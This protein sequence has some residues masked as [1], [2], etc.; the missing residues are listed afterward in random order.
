MSTE[1]PAEISAKDIGPDGDN[2]GQLNGQDSNFSLDSCKHQ[3]AVGVLASS[4]L[5]KPY[6]ADVNNIDEAPLLP[7]MTHEQ[8]NLEGLERIRTLRVDIAAKDL[9]V[10][11]MES[12]RRER[13]TRPEA[14]CNIADALLQRLDFKPLQALQN[15]GAYVQPYAAML[16][17][18][19]KNSYAD[20]SYG[21]FVMENLQH[22][23]KPVSSSKSSWMPNI[24]QIQFWEAVEEIAM[25]DE[26]A[27]KLWDTSTSPK[28]S[29]L[30]SHMLLGQFP[31]L[32][33]SLRHGE[34]KG[35]M[36]ERRTQEQ[37]LDKAVLD[38]K[39]DKEESLRKKLGNIK[40]N[41]NLKFA[42]SVIFSLISEASAEAVAEYP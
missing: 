30:K 38:G 39:E 29:M 9:I 11:K 34:T 32:L 31:I 4:V 36:A 20:L 25:Q 21:N 14:L 8:M 42:A 15:I 19:R 16:V 10:S 17:K 24:R 3:R 40:D 35:I 37:H 28:P 18:T 41:V 27:A 2:I 22:P 23:E 12:L 33:K 1:L 6:I 5:D 7:L 13:D 26:L